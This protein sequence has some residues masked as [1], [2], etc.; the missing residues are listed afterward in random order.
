MTRRGFRLDHLLQSFVCRRE[1]FDRLMGN[2]RYDSHEALATIAGVSPRTIIRLRKGEAIR[3][4]RIIA[5]AKALGTTFLNLIDTR[6]VSDECQD[7]LVEATFDMK[8]R[9]SGYINDR[10]LLPKLRDSANE[11]IQMLKGMGAVI[12]AHDIR[13][14]FRDKIDGSIRL[15]Y[16]IHGEIGESVDEEIVRNHNGVGR[17]QD[18]KA[19]FTI[20]A[21]VK[22]SQHDAFLADTNHEMLDLKSFQVYGELFDFRDIRSPKRILYGL[23]E[24]PEIARGGK[25]LT[26]EPV[27]TTSSRPDGMDIIEWIERKDAAKKAGIDDARILVIKNLSELKNVKY[28]FDKYNQNTYTGY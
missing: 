12:D 8:I 6:V 13:G 5:I 4:S 24:V 3:K 20:G 1:E 2:S 25:N 27:M 9:I 17:G 11:L 23:V 22:P 7:L 15:V 16:R 21:L 18:R 10:T 26:I 19:K 14:S 28:S